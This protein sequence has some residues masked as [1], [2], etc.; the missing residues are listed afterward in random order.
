M[1]HV[2]RKEAK[3]ITST[4]HEISHRIAHDLR[5]LWRAANG[6][7]NGSRYW[8]DVLSEDDRRLL[9]GNYGFAAKQLGGTVGIFRDLNPRVSVERAI[10]EIVHE[11]GL[12]LTV[13]YRQLVLAI[14]ER[15]DQPPEIGT[16]PHWATGRLIYRGEVVREVAGRA[17]NQIAVL[18]AFEHQAWPARISIEELEG[19]DPSKIRQTVYDLNCGL[20]GIY[21]VTRQNGIEWRPGERL[22][23]PTRHR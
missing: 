15:P 11:L 4:K 21:F 13:R 8:S 19:F 6:A 10:L 17:T 7:Y 22:R 20:K 3:M 5:L 14:G 12:V 23:K 18:N 9:G 1:I 16:R 2:N